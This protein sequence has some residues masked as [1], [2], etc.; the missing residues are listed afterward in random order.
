MHTIAVLSTAAFTFFEKSRGGKAQ[1]KNERIQH[2]GI[3][4]HS[5]GLVYSI[6]RPLPNRLNQLTEERNLTSLELLT[7]N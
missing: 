5:F 3:V 1:G 4:L 2:P 7:D 6:N